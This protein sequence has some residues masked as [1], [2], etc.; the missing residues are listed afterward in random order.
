[1]RKDFKAHELGMLMGGV[2]SSMGAGYPNPPDWRR[3]LEIVL[4]GL[5]AGR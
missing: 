5:R 3:H 1:M 4:D 2:C